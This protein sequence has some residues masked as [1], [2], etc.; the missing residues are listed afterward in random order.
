MINGLHHLCGKLKDLEDS[1]VWPAFAYK[2]FVAMDNE[3][4]AGEIQGLGGLGSL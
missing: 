1:H 4:A 2:R 3:H